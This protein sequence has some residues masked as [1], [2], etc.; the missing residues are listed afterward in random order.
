MAKT[1]AWHHGVSPPTRQRRLESLTTALQR[2]ADTGLG[3]ALIIANFHH[4][5]VV[6]LMERE[7]CIF[8]M[9]DAANPVSLAHSRLLQERFPKEYAAMRVRR[10][11]SLKSVP[12]SDDDLWSFVMLPDDQPVS[13]VFLFSSIPCAVF[14]LVLT[15]FAH[16]WLL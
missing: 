9:S 12:H 5:R 16:S 13:V 15:A 3:A 4:R 1:D 2:L 6:P 10:V 14:A 7:L 11:I 8:E